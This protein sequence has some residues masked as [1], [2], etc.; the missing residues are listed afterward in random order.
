MSG[1][2]RITQRRSRIGSPPGQRRTLDGLG[3]R[4][5]GSSVVR[6]D[7][8]AIRGMVFK[9]CH[10]VDVEAAAGPTGAGKGAGA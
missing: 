4:R 5:I 3:L 2:L 9:V 7:T 8:P 6:P 10:L 1:W